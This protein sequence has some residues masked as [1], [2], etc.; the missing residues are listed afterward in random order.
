MSGTAGYDTRCRGSVFEFCCFADYKTTHSQRP[1]WKPSRLLKNEQFRGGSCGSAGFSRSRYQGT[2]SSRAE[3]IRKQITSS[4]PKASAQPP[5]L[6]RSALKEVLLTSSVSLLGCKCLCLPR[7]QLRLGF[8]SATAVNVA[9]QKR[10]CLLATL[11][12]E[13]FN[14]YWSA[15]SSRK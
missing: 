9:M 7:E 10:V 6:R 2:T 5:Q 1:R 15:S 3:K 12:S 11:H 14:D 13:N 4:L 8:F